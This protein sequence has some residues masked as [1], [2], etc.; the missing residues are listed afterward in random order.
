MGKKENYA[1]L[2]LGVVSLL[3]AA[4]IA[5]S[6]SQRE[7]S[8]MDLIQTDKAYN[9]MFQPKVR[10]TLW[11]SVIHFGFFSAQSLRYHFQKRMKLGGKHGIVQ[12]IEEKQFRRKHTDLCRRRR[13]NDEH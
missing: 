12:Q 4:M 2:L 7:M 8:F 10:N 5:W 9:R 11:T 3:L 13:R 6:A 1:Q